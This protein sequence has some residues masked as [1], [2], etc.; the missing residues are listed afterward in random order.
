MFERYGTLPVG[1]FAGNAFGLYDVHGN[2]WEW[3]QD[4]Y[5]ASYEGAPTDGTA[6]EHGE[7]TRRVA[8][9]GSWIDEATY[10]RTAMRVP[11]KPALR[12]LTTGFR[13]ART[14]S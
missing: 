10:L 14:L 7:C 12:D 5:H 11:A 8:R 9:G 6:W 1:T 13:V 4:C 2:A 3:T